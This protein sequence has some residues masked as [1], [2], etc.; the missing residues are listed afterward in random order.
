MVDTYNHSACL[1]QKAGDSSRQKKNLRKMENSELLT[2]LLRLDDKKNPL[3][4]VEAEVF[5]LTSPLIECG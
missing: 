2:T 4:P 1:R 3:L 5:F